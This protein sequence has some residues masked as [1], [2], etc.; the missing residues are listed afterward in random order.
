[1]PANIN[2][3]AGAPRLKCAG[4]ESGT[5]LRLVR[6]S[7]GYIVWGKELIV[8]HVQRDL[9]NVYVITRSH[10]LIC[11]PTVP[12]IHRI[13]RNSELDSMFPGPYG[14]GS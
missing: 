8:A 14:P 13:Q 10:G 4:S 11:E 12:D 7:H 2:R 9:I 5:L 1:M 6:F 3:E